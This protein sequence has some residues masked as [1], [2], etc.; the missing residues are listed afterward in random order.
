[1]FEMSLTYVKIDSISGSVF[2][3]HGNT[4]AI[5]SNYTNKTKTLKQIYN[6]AQ[7]FSQRYRQTAARIQ[8]HRAKRTY[9]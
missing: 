6:A 1:M 4:Q 5:G 8:T 2:Q 9:S 3:I 7:M